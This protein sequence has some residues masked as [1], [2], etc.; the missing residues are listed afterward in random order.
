LEFW[1]VLDVK[2]LCMYRVIDEKSLFKLC[3]VGHY[4]EQREV[5]VL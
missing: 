1:I 5:S 2:L 3:H 4:L